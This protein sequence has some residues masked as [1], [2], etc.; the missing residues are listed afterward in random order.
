MGIRQSTP[1]RLFRL[2]KQEKQL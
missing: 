2:S 1:L